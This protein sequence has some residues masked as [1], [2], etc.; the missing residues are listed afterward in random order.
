MALA[1]ILLQKIFENTTL[2]RG[3]LTLVSSSWVD[4]CALRF[5]PEMPGL[6]YL[7]R[8]LATVLSEVKCG[9][10]T[11]S[12]AFSEFFHEFCTFQKLTA[13]RYYQY[14]QKSATRPFQ[15]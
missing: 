8:M 10:W 7:A 13:G 11:F 3:T 2:K 5:R 12:L 6:P 9:R 14:Y 4:G 15:Q 1:S